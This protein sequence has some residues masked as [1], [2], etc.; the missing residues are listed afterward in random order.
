MAQLKSTV[1]SGSLRAT[2][3][4]YT[5]TMQASIF[6]APSTSGGDTYG[7]GTSG[8]VLRSNGTTTYWASLGAAADKGITDNS[9]ETAVTSTDTNLITGRTLYN[10]GYVKSS[11]VVI[12]DSNSKII[13]NTWLL[14]NT[15]TGSSY[16]TFYQKNTTTFNAA[17][18]VGF[19]QNGLF[20]DG[21][22]RIG[23]SVYSND[24]PKASPPVNAYFQIGV[25]SGGALRSYSNAKIY[26]AVWNDYAEYRYTNQAA[27]PGSC[28][29]DNTDG[30]LSL[31]TKRLQPGAQIVSDTFGF[32][33]GE[34]D[35]CK[36][37]LAVSGRVLTKT[38]RDRYDYKAGMCVCS[39]P[40]GT[41]DIMTREEIQQY[42]DCIVG[43]VSEV[44]EYETWGTENIEVNKRIWIKVK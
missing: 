36:T 41:V 1:I 16:I 20:S 38:F 6:K 21:S 29:V 37:P 44:P 13:H 19:I 33:I 7:V 9:T 5:T 34:T 10:A 12:T 22:T 24:T 17:N 30:T 27:V 31:S 23:M 15:T 43:I 25:T 11:G 26:G 2:D 32:A 35:N 28:V 18:E 8:Q 14:G 39:A 4:L 3:T 40:N 42:P